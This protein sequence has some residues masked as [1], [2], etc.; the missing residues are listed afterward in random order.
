[1]TSKSNRRPGKPR[2]RKNSPN[3]KTLLPDGIPRHRIAHGTQ[4]PNPP[5]QKKQNPSAGCSTAADMRTNPAKAARQF[6][7]ESTI[8]RKGAGASQEPEPRTPSC[9]R[10]GFGIRDPVALGLDKPRP[11][12]G[13]RCDHAKSGRRFRRVRTRVSG[14]PKPLLNTRGCSGNINGNNKATL[15]FSCCLTCSMWPCGK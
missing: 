4:M 3:Q 6:P 15:R 14:I 11:N 10:R 7:S 1:V 2:E 5:H 13:I 9:G 12:P 8:P